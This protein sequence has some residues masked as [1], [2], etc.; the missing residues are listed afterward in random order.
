[1]SNAQPAEGLVGGSDSD[2]EVEK[3]S[4]GPAKSGAMDMDALRA[5]LDDVR[6]ALST[7]KAAG[8]DKDVQLHKLRAERDIVVGA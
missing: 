6:E 4:E 7:E 5:V 1:M 2:E 8:R 3:P